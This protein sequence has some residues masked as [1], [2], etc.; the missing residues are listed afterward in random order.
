MVNGE[1]CPEETL[2]NAHLKEEPEK[3]LGTEGEA[4]PERGGQPESRGPRR[5]EAGGFCFVLFGP[6]LRHAAPGPEI[7]PTPQRGQ[8][9]SLTH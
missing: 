6:C 9:G 5:Q 7:K 2:G 8:L 3:E 4:F 1:W